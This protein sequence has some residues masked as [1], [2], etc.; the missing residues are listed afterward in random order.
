L[1]LADI[2]KRIRDKEQ[3]AA[4]S[5]KLISRWKEQEER[6]AKEQEMASL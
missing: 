6:H 4:S 1:S 2:S 3:Y 5:M